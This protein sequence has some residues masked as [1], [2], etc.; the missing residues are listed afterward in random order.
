[1]S[2]KVNKYEYARAHDFDVFYE[3]SKETSMHAY[4]WLSEKE[5]NIVFTYITDDQMTSG[6]SIPHSKALIDKDGAI[7]LSHVNSSWFKVNEPRKSNAFIEA[8]KNWT[9]D[10]L[11]I[12]DGNEN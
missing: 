10:N 11:L 6:V 3:S 7:Y 5:P 4:V 8:Y 2:K 9:V 12:G 1:M